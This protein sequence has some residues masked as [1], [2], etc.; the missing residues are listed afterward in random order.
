WV[1]V[2]IHV[3]GNAPIPLAAFLTL[4]YTAGIGLT[5]AL[6]CYLYARWIRDRYQGQEL[7]FAAIFVLCEWFRSWFLTGFPWLYLGYAHVETPLAGWV[8]VGGVL[9]ATFIVAYSGAVIAS[10]LQQASWR[11]AIGV[12]AIWVAGP[13]LNLIDWVQPKNQNPVQVAMVQANIPQEIKWNRDNY[14]PTIKLYKAMSE[15]LWPEADIVI[16]PEAAI[17]TYYQNAKAYLTTMGDIASSHNATL[18][19]GLPYRETDSGRT[20]FYNSIMAVGEG[21]GLY[22][23]QR[24]VPFGEVVPFENQLRGII[25][26]FD[27]PMSNFTAGDKQQISL[28]AGDIKI[29]PFICY[30]IVYP[31]LVSSWFPESDLLVTI[32]NDAWFGKSVGPLQHLE[33]AQMRALE[34]GRYLVRATGNGVSAIVNERG[35]IER[36]SEQFKRE[37]L[38][39]EVMLMQGTTPFARLGNWP[40]LVISFGCCLLSLLRNRPSR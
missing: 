15:P 13:L 28:Q 20:R 6:F 23:K 14:L 10:C 17:P 11:P 30:E 32:S 21:Q 40:A 24:L 3:Y 38:S 12:I 33:M 18:I 31:Q 26:F 16:W 27:L 39:G 4:L 29:A 37:T 34:V 8:P 19:T 2:S 1:Y 25:E 5:H 9:I 35:K 7:G 22:H 36:Q